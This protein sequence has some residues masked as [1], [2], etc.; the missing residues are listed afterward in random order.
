MV[1]VSDKIWQRLSEQERTWLKQAMAEA[2]TF[3]RELWQK[4][5][6]AAMEEMEK[7][8]VT[9]LKVDT[10]PY[11]EAVKPVIKKHA[12]GDVKIYYDRIRA[13]KPPTA[14]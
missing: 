1:V 5:T 12:T 2:T 10:T 7:E 3:Q 14:E 6:V 4:A 13:A 9:I 8:G 11:R